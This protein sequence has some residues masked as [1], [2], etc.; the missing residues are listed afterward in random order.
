MTETAQREGNGERMEEPPWETER[1]SSSKE[2][3]PE[4]YSSKHDSEGLIQ[5]L[6]SVLPYK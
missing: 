6:R 2:E 1:N 3:S 4:N 5:L